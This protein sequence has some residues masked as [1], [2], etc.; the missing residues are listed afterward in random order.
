MSATTTPA[1]FVPGASNGD[2]E[3]RY[4]ELRAA[5]RLPE[6]GLPESRRIFSL[7]CRHS[8]RDCVV[9]VG[10][11]SPFDGDEVLAIFDF[12]SR[13]GFSIATASSRPDQRLGRHVYWV[14]EFGSA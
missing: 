3:H 4:E 5:A 7:S 2:A 1:F 12:G 11:P 13:E 6:G 14:T 10:G 9:E 8:G